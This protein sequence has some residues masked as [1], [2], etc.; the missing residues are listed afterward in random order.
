MAQCIPGYASGWTIILTKSQNS[1]QATSLK[2]T[3]TNTYRLI[4]KS[5]KLCD[6][7]VHKLLKVLPSTEVDPAY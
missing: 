7:T 1:R 5:S 4:N 3:L 6:V 2:V